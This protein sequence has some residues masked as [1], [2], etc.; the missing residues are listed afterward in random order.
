V[1]LATTPSKDPY[2]DQVRDIVLTALAGEAASVILFGSRVWGRPRRGSDVDVGILA[3]RALA[4]E[5]LARV[6]A[7][8][9]ES[10]VPYSVDVVDLSTVDEQ[11]RRKVLE[12]GV[13][14]TA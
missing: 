12:D 14:W 9:E 7:A 2:L 5:T 3:E 1:S 10:I 11:F 6:R 4:Q 13:R 8:L